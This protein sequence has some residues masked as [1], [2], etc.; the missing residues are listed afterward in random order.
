MRTIEYASEL[1]PL[2]EMSLPTNWITAVVLEPGH[3]LSESDL[4]EDRLLGQ[5]LSG[6]E[7]ETV[8][9]TQLR[10]LYY[11]GIDPDR[12]GLSRDNQISVSYDVET[13]QYELSTRLSE[14][15]V[16]TPD[17]ATDWIEDQ[18]I[19]VETFADTYQVLIDLA[20]DIHGLGRTGVR[21]LVETFETLD[22]IREADGG[23]LADV[24]HVDTENATALQTALDNLDSTG[25]DDPTPLELALRTHDGP[26][27]LDLQ[28][29]PISGELV[30]SD[31]SEPKYI[32]EGFGP[33]QSESDNRVLSDG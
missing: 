6:G 10:F 31:A 20:D 11:R 28:E 18:F 26:L 14:T 7:D 16:R 19:A 9:A 1:D 5:L 15:T 17:A 21:G 8:V 25:D 22:A 24:P 33:D 12:R 4:P 23:A 13:E 2:L 32:S 30:P 27:I 3:L 29:G